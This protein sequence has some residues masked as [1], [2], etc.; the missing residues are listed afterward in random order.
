M[1]KNYDLNLII[2]IFVS[3]STFFLKLGFEKYIGLPDTLTLS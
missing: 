1:I 2:V 3:F